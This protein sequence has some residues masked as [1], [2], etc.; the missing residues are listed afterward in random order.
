MTCLEEVC[1]KEKLCFQLH[2]LG[3]DYCDLAVSREIRCAYLG[4]KDE[5][6]L[7]LC[8]LSEE[9]SSKVVN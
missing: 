6:G 3:S 8:K 2:I 5:N 7:Y 4:E 1:K 9:D